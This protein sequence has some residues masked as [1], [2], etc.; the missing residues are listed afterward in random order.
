MKSVLAGTL[1]ACLSLTACNELSGTISLNKALDVVDKKGKT[2]AVSNGS[3]RAEFEYD[4]D[5]RLIE[6]EIKDAVQGK[7]DVEMKI[8]IP[9][10]TEIPRGSG[11][12]ELLG[13]QVGQNFDLQGELNTDV[14]ES[15]RE[16]GYE[17]CSYQDYEYVCR[18]VCR[19]YTGRDGRRHRDCRRECGHEY[20]TKYGSQR[21]EFHYVTTTVSVE[22]DL[23]ATSNKDMLGNLSVSRTDSVKHFDYQGV[24][25]R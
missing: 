20:V 2:V 12:I 8:L 4:Q 21:V 19:D 3:H 10:G 11:R 22:A 6:L 24:C 23:L 5:K 1:I 7:K 25:E 15:Q 9:A 18:P 14:R 16:S 17:Q 13:S